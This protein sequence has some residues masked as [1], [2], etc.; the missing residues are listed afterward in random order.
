[1]NIKRKQED[2]RVVLLY[3]QNKMGDFY[4]RYMKILQLYEKQMSEWDFVD[5]VAELIMDDSKPSFPASFVNFATKFQICEHIVDDAVLYWCWKDDSVS[6]MDEHLLDCLRLGAST[7]MIGMVVNS[8]LKPEELQWGRRDSLLRKI[9][10]L[11]NTG[12]GEKK[13]IR[14]VLCP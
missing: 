8:L 3:V 10:K 14:E 4:S 2:K 5:F 11:K 7:A 13:R 6:I 9:L 1:M 12:E